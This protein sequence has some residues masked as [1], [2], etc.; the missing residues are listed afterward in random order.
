MRRV[1]LFIVGMSILFSSPAF[2][3]D[4]FQWSTFFPNIFTP[5]CSQKYPDLCNSID[6]C[7]YA[8]LYWYND[9]CNPSPSLSDLDIHNRISLIVDGKLVKFRAP[10]KIMYDARVVGVLRNGR[11]YNCSETLIDEFTTGVTR[12]SRPSW[13]P[14]VYSAVTAITNF[15]SIVRKET[16]FI[17]DNYKYSKSI[18]FF[19]DPSGKVIVFVDKDKYFHN[20][21]NGAVW[22]NSP[23]SLNE[24]WELSYPVTFFEEFY[25]GSGEL[26]EQNVASFTVS[27]DVV[28]KELVKVNNS[29]RYETF[30]INYRMSEGF[31]LGYEE[32]RG[33]LW[34]HPK[35]G[36][37]KAEIEPYSYIRGGCSDSV[38]LSYLMTSSNFEP[39][40]LPYTKD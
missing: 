20:Y 8:G 30:K 31:T 11:E 1:G 6:K 4:D 26:I 7:F 35:I 25:G 16:Y 9:S 37:V 18:D 21:P 32:E 12:F 40:N 3:S 17:F 33:Q 23:L 36:V 15:S 39:V 13:G 24:S 29:L 28:G 34:I 5:H 2:C 14:S 19:Q 38:Q 10:Y 22:V 27:Y